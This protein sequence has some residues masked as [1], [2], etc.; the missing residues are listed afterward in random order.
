[1]RTDVQPTSLSAYDAVRA[2]GTS[3]HQCARILAHI[4]QHGGD[5]SIGE[6]AHALNMEKSTVSARL[7]AML[8]EIDPPIVAK[9]TRKD[10]RSGVMVRPVGLPVKGQ[11]ELFS[12]TAQAA[13]PGPADIRPA[14]T[15]SPYHGELEGE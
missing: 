8:N 7:N 3:S 11:Q 12:M 10:R 13:Q 4:E 9:P 1:M 6:I 15:P 14:G 5:W 2:S